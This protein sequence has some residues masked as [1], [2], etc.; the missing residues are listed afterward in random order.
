MDASPAPK[1]A[2]NKHV[3]ENS[4]EWLV[5]QYEKS[6]DFGQL[7]P[8]S[9]RVRSQILQSCL[10]EPV[11][12]TNPLR[13]AECPVDRLDAKLVRVLRDR[14]KATP[15]AAGTRIK[16]LR[17]MLSWAVENGHVTVNVA[18]DVKP[19]AAHMRNSGNRKHTTNPDHMPSSHR[20]YAV[21]RST[22]SVRIRAR[23][24]RRRRRYAS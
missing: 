7:D 22:V 11:S 5:R 2:P 6:Y 4:L 12:E 17:V 24:D 14:K 20:R 8:R 21:G 3:K 15:G 18:R 10:D 19:L 13:F 9:Q 23:S 1:A 16:S